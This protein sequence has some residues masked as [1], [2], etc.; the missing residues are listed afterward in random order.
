MKAEGD[1]ETP[2]ASLYLV[3]APATVER[4]GH[5]L[6]FLK[7]NF[8][9]LVVERLEDVDDHDAPV[10][11][12][13]DLCNVK[14]KGLV[15]VSEFCTGASDAP[16][17]PSG[18]VPILVHGVGVFWRRCFDDNAFEQVTSAH[19]F[20]NL[21]ES[22][23]PSQAFRTGIYISRVEDRDGDLHFNLLR[24]SSNFSGPTDNARDCDERIIRRAN[25]LVAQV[26]QGHASLNHVLA[27]V[28]VNRIEGDKMKK[29]TIKSHS[30]KTKDMPRNGLIAFCTFYQRYNDLAGFAVPGGVQCKNVFDYH[31]GSMS[32]LTRLRFKLKP[33]IEG[34]VRQFDVVLY[35]NSMFVITLK[36]N[37]MYTH[38]I[39]P[40]SLPVEY[41]P[42]RLGYV[43]RCSQTKAFHT[44]DGETYIVSDD[45]VTTQ[46]LVDADAAGVA[47]VKALYAQENATD[48][49]VEYGTVL[50]SMNR[51]DYI[52]PI[53]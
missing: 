11:Y 53:L 52:K 39:V 28:Y 15:A 40:S 18:E 2:I 51:G 49:V 38:Q 29:A 46:R 27:Q 16:R 36:T 26:F 44:R 25:A 33:G 42:T 30:D 3:C 41:L 37:R 7:E 23:K 5:D 17:V 9:G 1:D 21:T 50:F 8:C 47:A 32:V 43:I 34:P 45:G 4:Y 48:A 22:N 35:P 12:T 24:C 31:Y 19:A 20:Q 13:G 6:L 10:F 14:R